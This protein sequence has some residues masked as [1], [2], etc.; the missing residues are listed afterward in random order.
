MKTKKVTVSVLQILVFIL[1]ISI[2]IASSILV[3]NKI[4]ASKSNNASSQGEKSEFF[5]GMGTEES[6]YL[7]QSATDLANISKS[8]NNGKNYTQRYFKL[9]NDIDFAESEIL[10]T[11]SAK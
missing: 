7:I 1:V 8:V 3:I 4:N 11:L 5:S 2:I 10:K 6:P 9:M